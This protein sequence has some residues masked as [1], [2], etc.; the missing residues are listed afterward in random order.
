MTSRALFAFFLKTNL[1]KKRALQRSPIFR[2]R[3]HL[4]RFAPST[5][6]HALRPARYGHN[7]SLT[8]HFSGGG[9]DNKCNWSTLLGISI[10]FKKPA[11]Q[12]SNLF[13]FLSPFSVEVWIYTCTAYLG[14][15]ITLFAL[16]RLT[17]YEWQN[18]H[19]CRQQPDILE[20]NFTILNCMWFTIGSLL[21]QGC[22][23]LPK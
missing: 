4:D 6:V 21:Q 23:F 3:Y 20:N 1:K 12:E 17:P 14:M 10:L 5:R 9:A 15:S 22:D 16:S 2:F 18:P 7:A 11:K 8:T 13:S 19:P